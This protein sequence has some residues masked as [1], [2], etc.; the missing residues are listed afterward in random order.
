MC[1]YILL[2][3]PYLRFFD[4]PL[5]TFNCRSRTPQNPQYALPS[6]QTNPPPLHLP[7]VVRLQERVPLNF[8]RSY[9]WT[10]TNLDQPGPP[11]PFKLFYFIFS[12]KSPYFHSFVPCTC[13]YNDRHV[14]KPRTYNHKQC[15]TLY[16]TIPVS[17]SPIL[18]LLYPLTRERCTSKWRKPG[19][20]SKTL[21]PIISSIFLHLTQIFWTLI[22]KQSITSGHSSSITTTILYFQ[23][24]QLVRFIIHI[25]K[26]I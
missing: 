22:M 26:N 14:F 21:L 19:S 7:R 18:W 15:S 13:C 20:K 11:K 17:P 16:S 25:L 1:I 2:Y 24:P 9:L 23:S 6:L 12:T 3:L 4:Q 10:W 5:W 8:F